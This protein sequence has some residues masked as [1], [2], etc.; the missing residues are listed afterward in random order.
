M[1]FLIAILSCAQNLERR[2][3]IRKTWVKELLRADY[4]FFLGFP[5]AMGS[6]TEDEEYVSCPD[7]LLSLSQKT[8]AVM[9]WAA[10]LDYDFVFKCD[11]DTYLRPDRLLDSGFEKHDYSGFIEDRDC[12]LRAF[13]FPVYPHAAGGPGYWLSRKAMNI[14][15]AELPAIP[16]KAEDFAVG[17]VLSLAGI[18]SFHDERYVHEDRTDR[19]A[20]LKSD[21]ISL[22]KCDPAEMRR[23]HA[24]VQKF[25]PVMG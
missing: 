7:D 13:N 3:A 15:A 14:V 4:K 8:K 20:I 21:F 18:K 25:C 9:Q 24:H 22:H 2:L 23:V 19:T 6:G 5:G 16:A 11:D 17:E 1:R 10:V 12:H